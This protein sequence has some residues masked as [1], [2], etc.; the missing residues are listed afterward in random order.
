M[1]IL[2]N[3]NIH[4]PRH[5]DATAL[6]IDRG[7][8]VAF[9]TDTDILN[10]FSKTKLRFDLQGRTV[11]PGLT[12]SHLH[13]HHLADSLSIVDCEAQTLDECL[14]RIKK[15]AA[16]I[17]Q[18]AWI[19]GHGWNQNL[20]EAGF[21][22]AKILDKVCDGRPAFL[23]AKSLHAAWVNSRALELAN[24]KSDTPDPPGGTHPAR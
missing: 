13:L 2:Y 11:W 19:R 5:G 23:T 1:Q 21:G 4:A 9:G 20:W 15:A 17:S 22:N 16:T 10:G 7:Q 12:D 3:A 6:V 8:F 24:I 18:S 14:C